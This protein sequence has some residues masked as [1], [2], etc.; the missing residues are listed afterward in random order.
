MSVRAKFKVESVLKFE[1]SGTV[2]MI[3]VVSGSPDNESFF[4][5]TPWGA[6]K[7]GT[8]NQDAIAE[9]S[10]GDEFYVDFT[11]ANA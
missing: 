2:E 1:N 9:F 3:P 6:I 5:C 11:K 8:I 7:I 10:S 4:K